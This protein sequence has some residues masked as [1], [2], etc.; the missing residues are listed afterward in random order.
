MTSDPVHEQVLRWYAANARQLP[1]RETGVD[2]WRVLVSEVM[3][4]QTPVARVHP[5]YEAWIHRW[6]TPGALAADSPGEAVRMWGRLGYPRRALRLHEAATV[7]DEEHDGVVPGDVETLRSLPGVGEY[8]ASAVAAF[9]YR[10]RAVVLDTNVRR[11]I[12]RAFSGASLPPTSISRTERELAESMLPSDGDVAATWSVGLMELGALLCTATSPKCVPCPLRDGCR[13]RADGYPPDDGPPR[14]AQT[15]A[16][17]DRQCRGRILAVLR[18][19]EG[20]VPK[21]AVEAAWDDR[22]QRE[23]ALASLIDDGLVVAAGEDSL[24]LPG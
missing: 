12:A 19:A 21:A 17:T 16:G 15:Y 8:T 20:A 11:V 22:T 13:W 14:K 3:L 6:P 24:Q 7:V 2:G 18:D 1:W 9:A 10:R 23:R 4:Q 5:A